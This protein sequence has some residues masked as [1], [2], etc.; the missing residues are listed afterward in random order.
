[1]K[2][3]LDWE[4]FERAAHA[5]L[6]Q[7]RSARV[8]LEGVRCPRR[9]AEER[10]NTMTSRLWIL[11]ASDPEMQAIEALLTERG[12]AVVYAA[13]FGD[14]VGPRRVHPSEAYAD[15]LTAIDGNGLWSG[16]PGGDPSQV[17]IYTVEC[18]LPPG[19]GEAQH[20][21]VDHHR[22]GD[23]G[24]GKPPREFLAASSIGQ[25]IA[26]LARLDLFSLGRLWDGGLIRSADAGKVEWPA[27]HEGGYYDAEWDGIAGA[28]VMRGSTWAVELDFSG[29]E[30]GSWD[31]HY[32]EIPRDLVL[33][34]AADHCLGAAYRGEC[35]GV[36]PDELMRWRAGSRAAF[37]G[38]SVEDV[39]ADIGIAQSR[40]RKAPLI[41]LQ[42]CWCSANDGFNGCRP[43]AEICQACG[44]LVICVRDL[45]GDDAQP[46][47][48][49]A[50]VPELPE[51]ALRLGEAYIAG[52]LN[53]ADGRSKI[54]CSGRPEHVRAFLEHWA[55]AQG[56]T[57][58]Y[59]DPMRGFAGGYLP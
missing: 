36:D 32:A 2:I 6:S 38:R 42:G 21:T 26:E 53:T 24:Y 29:C 10:K 5:A 19:T 48:R 14:P 37:Q 28:F 3:K 58:T 52:P 45:T 22:P 16:A 30:D 39:L 54:V 43:G 18:A 33:T 20:V 11:G 17:T 50:A 15:D 13:R 57:D 46:D 51:A 56:L 59:G 40:I 7:R 8:V 25:V 31:A 23:P 4:R 55:P 1:M 12:E 44:G 9:L 34:A 35:P 49:G 41:I 27:W 47:T